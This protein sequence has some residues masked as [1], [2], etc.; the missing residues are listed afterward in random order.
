MLATGRFLL[1]SCLLFGVFKKPF[2]EIEVFAGLEKQSCLKWK[3]ERA[4]LVFSIICTRNL[5]FFNLQSK[6][7]EKEATDLLQALISVTI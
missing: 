6:F 3:T 5:L 7:V 4:I 2:Y 1:I